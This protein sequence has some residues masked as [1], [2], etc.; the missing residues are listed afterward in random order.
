MKI[1]I[2]CEE[3][4]A[5]TIAMRGK[6]H[7]AYSCDLQECTGGHLKWHICGDVLPLL[8]GHCTFRTM[9]G[10]T[11]TVQDRWDM[12][13]AHPPCTYLS[14]VGSRH[15]SL[16]VSSPEKVVKRWDERA[17][18]VAFFMR[19][20]A[21]DCQKIAVENPAGYMSTCYRVPDQ[22]I[23]P[24]M[25]CAGPEDTENYTAKRTGLWLKGLPLLKGNG[26][27]TEFSNTINGRFPNGKPISWTELNHGS[28]TRS[29]TFPAVAQAMA[30]QWG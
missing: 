9:D 20:I 29:K 7:E 17:K 14:N 6:G 10:Q 11:H 2:A 5:V 18:A 3:S 13:I 12:L 24:W 25:F 1:L 16:R 8:N 23:N 4:Q 28:V 15:F 30:D 21:A 22:Y 19:F 26:I 27:I